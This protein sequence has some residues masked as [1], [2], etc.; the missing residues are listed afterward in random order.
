M[1]KKVKIPHIHPVF[2]HI[3]TVALR[4][5]PVVFRAVLI[6]FMTAVFSAIV[7]ETVHTEHEIDC[8]EDNC[9]ICLILQIIHNTQKKSAAAQ[10]ASF[11]FLSFF[12]INILILSAVLLIPATL[13]KQK[14]KL[15]I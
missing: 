4:I 9:A 12:Y 11:E 15:V 8:H 7:F 10:A 13:V 5:Q 14:I 1:N 2:P 6:L 3:H